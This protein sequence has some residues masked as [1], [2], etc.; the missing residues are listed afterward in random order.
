MYAHVCEE[1]GKTH[2]KVGVKLPQTFSL[3]GYAPSC[4]IVLDHA[5]CSELAVDRQIV[6][7]NACIAGYTGS[8]C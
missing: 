5:L 1:D 4:S 8:L 7:L 6:V 3:R 2:H